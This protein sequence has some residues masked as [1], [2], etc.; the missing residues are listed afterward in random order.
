MTG[1]VIFTIQDQ[2]HFNNILEMAFR[3][4]LL[5]RKMERTGRTIFAT[6]VLIFVPPPESLSA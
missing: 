1:S 4:N 6:H 2:Q 3:N 5:D